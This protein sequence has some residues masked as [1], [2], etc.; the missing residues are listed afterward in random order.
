MDITESVNKIIFV[1]CDIYFKYYYRKCLSNDLPLEINKKQRNSNHQYSFLYHGIDSGLNFKYRKDLNLEKVNQY[2]NNI[3]NIMVDEI[4]E[5]IYEENALIEGDNN[6][7]KLK[8]DI[9]QFYL[10]STE[11]AITG[12]NTVKTYSNGYTDIKEEDRWTIGDDIQIELLINARNHG[13]NNLTDD[14]INN[15]KGQK[16]NDLKFRNMIGMEKIK[17]SGV[18]GISSDS[19]TIRN[20]KK[21]MDLSVKCENI[22]D[23]FNNYLLTFNLLIKKI[24]END[25]GGTTVPET[26]HAWRVYKNN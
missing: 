6:N 20:V 15:M 23:E 10:S 25:S 14:E 11:I 8:H 1:D 22:N 17:H 19:M 3:L 4:I 13:K 9:Y 5:K 12:E 21:C 24:Y 7:E 26:S 16:I 18:I 2:N